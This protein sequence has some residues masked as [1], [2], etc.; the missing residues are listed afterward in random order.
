MRSRPTITFALA[1]ALGAGTV[2]GLHAQGGTYTKIGEVHIGGAPRFDYLTAD[3]VMKRLYVSHGTEA[4]VIDLASREGRRHDYRHA[5]HPRHCAGA[6][7]RQGL[8]EQRRA[9][10]TSASSMPGR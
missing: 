9:T 3:P 1:A 4:V 2:L 5:R 10:T 8:H 6:R 7:S